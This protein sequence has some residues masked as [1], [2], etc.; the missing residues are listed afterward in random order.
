M[1]DPLLASFRTRLAKEAG[2]ALY[3]E[4]E[5]ACAARRELRGGHDDWARLCE[6]AGLVNLAFREWQLAA[7]DAP[8]DPPTV[9][10]LVQ[11]YR[12]R[13]DLAR[14]T[15]G[16][17]LLLACSP[18]QE[19][20][21]SLLLELLVEQGALPA[22][23][24]ALQ[25][26]REAGLSDA[27]VAALQARLLP[28]EDEPTHEGSLTFTEADLVRFQALFGG[29]EDVH[30]R[31][32]AKPS[33]ETGYTPVREPLTPA[34]VR[35]HLLGT[36][37]V[38][39]YPI[40]LDGTSTF[41]VLDLD[42]TR[43]SLERAVS[44]SALARQLRESMRTEGVRLLNA[45]RR[46]FGLPV[47]FEDSGYKGRHF[48]IFLEQPEP[49]EVLHLLGR[50][51]LTRLTPTLAE[52][53]HLE[54]FPKQPAL[55]NQ[56]LGNLIKLPLGV[57][58]RTG[59]RAVLL[60]EHGQPL[61]EPLAALRQVHR[62]SR[63]QLY[64]LVERLKQEAPPLLSVEP[65]PKLTEPSPPTPAEGPP[66]PEPRPAWTEADFET[67]PRVRHLLKQCPVLA[68]LKRQVD[69][70]RRLNHEEQLVLIHSLG[71]LPS[72]PQAVNYLLSHCVDVPAEKLLKSPLRGHPISCPSIRKKIGHVTR[73]VPCNC[74][75][76]QAPEHYPTPTLHLIGLPVVEP[77]P[78]AVPT[79][80]L[81]DLARRYGVLT[82]RRDEIHR[83]WDTMRGELVERLRLAPARAVAC[84]GGRFRL[85]E[86]EGVEELVWEND[87]A[88]T[89]HH[90]SG[91]APPPGGGVAGDS[92]SRGNHSPGAPGGSA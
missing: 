26:A 11:C 50:L 53:L 79:Q 20:W 18:A 32:W 89:S 73:R 78:T 29:R 24:A 37:T 2:S 60:D 19:A 34:V 10:R 81:E 35:N 88:N 38:G 16:V 64:S 30:A 17:E 49:A 58:R 91:T 21:L 59:R 66:P 41:F 52:G 69:S 14:A 43:S 54:Y 61:A 5:A 63:E 12:E 55:K 75:F 27:A 31:Q 68:E 87:D 67:D 4:I 72:G 48:W 77:S 70:E 40:R 76:A 33:G 71:H 80:S 45:L 65:K 8:D 44:E 84:P 86:Q 47:L 28:P 23:Q 57:H 42:I 22:A 9:L 6:E 74:S 7:R 83:E 82:R 85:I 36:F 46:D 13:G 92:P 15:R 62:L 25:R 56:G 90:R 39:T 51:L 1:S 3:R